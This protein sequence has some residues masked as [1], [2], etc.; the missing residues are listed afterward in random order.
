[1]VSFDNCC[2]IFDMGK[3]FCAGIISIFKI[4]KIQVDDAVKQFHGFKGTVHVRIPD[5]RKIDVTCLQHLE[6][7][8]KV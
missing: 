3:S 8:E 7:I 2:V 4:S 5:L 6:D 1:M